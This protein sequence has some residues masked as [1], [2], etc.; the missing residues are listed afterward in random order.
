MAE[1]VNAAV[2]RP[3]SGEFSAMLCPEASLR[4]RVR[5][6]DLLVTVPI[7]QWLSVFFFCCISFY[8][9]PPKKRANI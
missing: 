2:Q 9:E 5:L 3:S 7:I 8:N 4:L 1:P 6:L